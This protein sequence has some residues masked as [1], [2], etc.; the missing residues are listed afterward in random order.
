MLWSGSPNDGILEVTLQSE[1][2]DNGVFVIA[3]QSRSSMMVYLQSRYNEEAS[4]MVSY[5]R[6]QIPLQLKVLVMA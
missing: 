4:M 2:F 6:V 5:I 3:L 1:S